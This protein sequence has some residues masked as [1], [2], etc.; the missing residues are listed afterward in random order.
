MPEQT[1][2]RFTR[3]SYARKVPEATFLRRLRAGPALLLDGGLASE[4]ERRGVVLNDPLWSSSPLLFAPQLIQDV[5]AAYLGAGCEVCT[6][7]TYQASRGALRAKGIDEGN[8]RR[9]L[10]GSVEV[11]RGAGAPFV[12]GSVGPYGAVL[13]GGREYRGDYD[14]PRRGYEDFHRWRMEA[15]REGGVEVIAA[16]T[17]PRLDEARVMAELADELQVPLWLSFTL[18]DERTLAGGDDLAAAGALA[19]RHPFVVAVG[20]NC[21]PPGLVEGALGCL[22]QHTRKPLVAYPNLGERWDDATKRWGPAPDPD[23]FAER[24]PAWLA[25]GARVVGGCCR[26]GPREIAALAQALQ[27]K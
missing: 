12:A 1:T 9:L 4:L 13:S 11:A 27:G 2:N 5:H 7:A 25:L 10:A 24:L 19:E 21:V 22:R 23:L 18:R 20:V 26:T 3:R 8:A 17:L 14:L 15:L 16:E 6:T